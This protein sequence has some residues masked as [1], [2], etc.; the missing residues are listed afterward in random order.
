M[1][2]CNKNLDVSSKRTQRPSIDSIPHELL[3]V[4]DMQFGIVELHVEKRQ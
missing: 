1:E 3:L 2:Y 4:V